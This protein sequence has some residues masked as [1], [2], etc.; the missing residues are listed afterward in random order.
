MCVCIYVYILTCIFPHTYIYVI[1]TAVR[2]QR[3]FPLHLD[4]VGQCTSRHRC[5]VDMYHHCCHQQ[6][7]YPQLRPRTL[8]LT[9]VTALLAEAVIFRMSLLPFDADP[10]IA[11]MADPCTG[12]AAMTGSCTTVSIGKLLMMDGYHLV[13][14]DVMTPTVTERGLL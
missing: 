4:P 5:N 3:S 1:Q 13:V 8:V 12:V 6:C 10:S 7:V 11:S 14:V 2:C 9:L